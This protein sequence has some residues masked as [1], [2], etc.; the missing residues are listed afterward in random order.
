MTDQWSRDTS[1]SYVYDDVTGDNRWTYDP[2]NYG[3]QWVEDPTTGDWHWTA[4]P[5]TMYP[6]V[7]VVYMADMSVRY[8]NSVP[9]ATTTPGL[10]ADLSFFLVDEVPPGPTVPMSPDWCLVHSVTE[11]LGD[12]L[13]F[14]G[15]DGMGNPMALA[16]QNQRYTDD[17]AGWM[18]ADFPATG[19]IS[20]AFAPERSNEAGTDYEPD[21]NGVTYTFTWDVVDLP[22][23]AGVFDPG[24]HTIAEVLDYLDAHPDELDAVQAAEEAGQ[25]RVTLLG[26]LE[27]R[28][29]E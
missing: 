17:P 28:Q 4:P 19:S 29:G 24:D 10:F 23:V 27:A 12:T 26:E 6:I 18:A 8:I 5:K 9:M 2:S 1:G 13:R 14:T 11:Q 16:Y 25:A 7:A 22:P 3:L 15:D 21:P 20:E